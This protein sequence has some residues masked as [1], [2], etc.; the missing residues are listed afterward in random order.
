MTDGTLRLRLQPLPAL[1][2]AQVSAQ[3]DDVDEI[4]ATVEAL[5]WTLTARLAAAGAPMSGRVIRTY[6][7]RPDG[8]KI[9][10]AVGVTLAQGA[11][12]AA[13]LESAGLESAGLE[14][15]ELPAVERGAVATH[16]RAANGT[17]DPWLAVDAV[18]AERGLESWGLYRQVRLEDT[19]DD[20][21][22]FELQCPVREIGGGCP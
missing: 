11:D 3:V 22:V 9:D 6:S 4:A 17:D 15:A 16:R 5:F 21:H 1:R 20:R 8:S 14:S 18:L 13:G 19:D 12:P 2:L 7:G 10:V